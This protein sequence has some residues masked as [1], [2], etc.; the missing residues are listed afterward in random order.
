MIRRSSRWAFTLL[1]MSGVL[2]LLSLIFLLVA[3][4]L[5]GAL[6]MQS[7][8]DAE[9]ARL[10][11]QAALADQFRDDV[12]RSTA[13]LPTLGEQKTGPTC[14][15]LRQS[16]TRSLVYR[17][18]ER[19]LERQAID[20]KQEQRQQIPV[21]SEVQQVEFRTTGRLVTL[22]LTERTDRQAPLQTLE[23][24]ATLGEQP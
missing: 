12:R 19:R 11:V 5:L 6:R 18:R 4:L 22:R 2:M 7:L 3:G 16:D 10:R 20:G 13:V 21:G 15:I 1:E 24:S 9:L 17:W 23:L 8:S 14:L